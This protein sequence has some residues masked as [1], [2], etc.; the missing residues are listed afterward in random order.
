MICHPQKSIKNVSDHSHL[1]SYKCKHIQCSRWNQQKMITR[2]NKSRGYPKGHSPHPSHQDKGAGATWKI[3]T[4]AGAWGSE[5][6]MFSVRTRSPHHLRGPRWGLL[7]GWLNRLQDSSARTSKAHILWPGS[8]GLDGHPWSF[9]LL[10][11]LQ[12]QFLQVGTRGGRRMLVAPP[13]MPDKRISPVETWSWSTR[14]THVVAPLEPRRSHLGHHGHY[15]SQWE[16]E[17]STPLTVAPMRAIPA[18]T[19]GGEK[20][21]IDGLPLC[22]LWS[23]GNDGLPYIYWYACSIS[24]QTIIITPT[25]RWRR[26]TPCPGCYSFPSCAKIEVM[27]STSLNANTTSDVSLSNRNISQQH[28]TNKRGHV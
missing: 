27:L 24:F 23:S 21:F 19:M 26:A 15:P 6:A 16:G 2:G 28:E 3:D 22:S 5:M 25:K 18:A 4:V 14:G 1:I 17:S 13:L 8:I 20:T 12:K 7:T 10:L 11:S 9:L